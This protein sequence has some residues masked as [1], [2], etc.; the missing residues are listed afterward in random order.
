MPKEAKLLLVLVI[1]V[2]AFVLA[3]ATANRLSA[4]MEKSRLWRRWMS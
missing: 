2:I 4:P 1:A 3:N